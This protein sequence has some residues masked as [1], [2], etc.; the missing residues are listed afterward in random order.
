MKKS[1]ET[2]KDWFTIE[3]F[4]GTG[5]FVT[6]SCHRVEMKNSTVLVDSGMY[7]G[8]YEERSERGERRNFEP[9]KDMAAG[10]TEVMESHTHID[11]IGRLPIIF[12][13]GFT[14]RVLV[15][16]ETAAFMEP[17]LLNSAEIQKEENPQNRLY[18][19]YDVDKTLRYIRVVKPFTKIP[20]GQKRS[21]VTAEFLLNGHVMGSACIMIRSPDGKRSILFTGD[22]GKPV[23]SLCG[24]YEDYIS[25]Y[26]QNPVSA[27]VV[28]ST[29][30]EKSP[31]SFEEKRAELITAIKDVWAGGGNPVFPVLSFHRTQEIMEVL[32]NSQQEGIIPP[33]CQIFIDAP[34]AMTLL[35]TF[36][37]LGPGHLS[38]R[39]GDDPNFYRSDESSMDRFNL[40]RVHIIGSH[41]ESQLTDEGLADYQGK[42]IILASGGMGGYGRVVNYL[43]GNFCKNPKNAVIL[44][45]FQVAGTEGASLLREG[46]IHNGKKD[47]ARVIKIE[48]FTSHISGPE[49]T[50]E[51][52]ESL[53][54]SELEKVIITHGKDSARNAMA[55]EFKR[56]GYPAEIIL[57]KVGQI[58][59]V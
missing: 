32:H 2:S 49:E 36:K 47:G 8:K 5:G 23:Q 33:D 9:I 42:V 25:R 19:T 57:S 53:N 15:T 50:F 26:P 34:L 17:M 48:G 40:R 28:E 24:G 6:G 35:D 16:E 59:K 44:T 20:I 38:K 11:H 1:T 52:L 54:L 12:K 14:P 10:V 13:K 18:E 39:Y 41:E 46:K 37:Q 30:F 43:R 58:I 51:F 56:R 7:Q 27:L 31:I 21:G 55:D 45:C 29:N 22:M 3:S 4:G